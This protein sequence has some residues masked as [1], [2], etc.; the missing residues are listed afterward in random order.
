MSGIAERVYCHSLAST[1][2]GGSRRSPKEGFVCLG[3][4]RASAKLHRARNYS[5]RGVGGWIE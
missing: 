3:G 4:G 1:G 5:W 2:M